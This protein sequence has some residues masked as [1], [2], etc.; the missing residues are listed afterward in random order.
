VKAGTA[1]HYAIISGE[2]SDTKLNNV[3]VTT[4]G[5]G[6][7]AVYGAKVVFDDGSI[8]LNSPSTSGRYLFYTEG[9]GSEIIINGGNFDFNKTQNQKRAY[10][11][12]SADTTVIINGG[13]F[14]KASSRSGFT[15]GILG[16]GTVIIY[17]GTFGFNPSAWVA[18][19]YEAIYDAAN[20]VWTVSAI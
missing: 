19:G 20:S 7:A 11:Y 8:D 2:D 14:G 13:T 15:A 5:G 3:D 12:A 17:G 10:V 4:A 1:G 6:I 18:S 16:E 9:A